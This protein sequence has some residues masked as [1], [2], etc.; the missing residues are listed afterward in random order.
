E[1][2]VHGL[3]EVIERDAAALVSDGAEHAAERRLDIESIDDPDCRAAVDAIRGAGLELAVWDITSDLGIAAFACQILEGPDGPGLVALPAEGHGCHPD[4]G[5]A[6]LRALTEAAQ[7]R[8]T[9]I[10]G[11]REDI[12]RARY[13]AGAESER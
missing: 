6:L 1:A 10:A 4:R 8:L 13:R 12:T 2:I 3:C 5:V 11:G 7:T 9:A